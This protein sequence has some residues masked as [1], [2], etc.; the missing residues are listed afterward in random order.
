MQWRFKAELGQRTRSAH[1]RLRWRARTRGGVRASKPLPPSVA[2]VAAGV[3]VAAVVRKGGFYWPD[4]VILPGLLAVLAAVSVRR[5]SGSERPIVMALAMFLGW[6]LIAGF[7]WGVP[8]R[9]LR[10][11]GSVVGFG[12]AVLLGARLDD[13]QQR[14]L[15]CGVVALGVATAS[16]GLVGL[17]AHVHPL[18]MADGAVWRLATTLTYANA[19]GLLLALTLPAAMTSS[20]ISEP[21]RRVAVF[22]ILTALVLTL[23]RGALLAGLVPPLFLGRQRLAASLWPAIVAGSTAL[24]LV[25]TVS[26]REEGVGQVLALI[27]LSV[28]LALAI[29]GPGR[30]RPR[31]LH[32]V[33]AMATVALVVAGSATL[34][35]SLTARAGLASVEARS[36]GWT[37]ALAD[38]DRSPLVGV[39]PE[40]NLGVDH[41]RL[42]TYFA[43]N[44]YLQIAS[45]AGTVGVLLLGVVMAS[46]GR[47]VRSSPGPRAKMALASLLALAIGGVFDFGWHLPAIAMTAGWITALSLAS[48]VNLEGAT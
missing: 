42:F 34:R 10:L 29:R 32:A 35:S 44:E 46:L 30:L 20:G 33:I 9:A 14:W 2:G 39:G 47:A 19:A 6:W 3:T 13:R 24:V 43:H 5:L 22:V 7:G 17:V 45:G 12:A 23:S 4:Y 21:W 18:A 28:G 41:G 36:E 16:L 31:P 11:A 1:V 37:A 15:E 48:T 40:R 26:A 38:L 25:A 27:A 8:G